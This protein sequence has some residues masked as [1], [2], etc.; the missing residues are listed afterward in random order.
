MHIINKLGTRVWLHLFRLARKIHD[1][2]PEKQLE[3]ELINLQKWRR[4]SW[5][6]NNIHLRKLV[7]RLRHAG[8]WE[9]LDSRVFLTGDIR[10]VPDS[11]LNT[12]HF[13]RATCV[14]S[15]YL[16][17]LNE[18]KTECGTMDTSN[19]RLTVYR[20]HHQKWCYAVIVL[21]SGH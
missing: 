12:L 19:T 2:E 10:L 7:K 4:G 16:F 20:W 14:P 5:N 13:E 1:K 8:G 17:T 6:D 21:A 3:L 11:V 9:E 18:P 15:T